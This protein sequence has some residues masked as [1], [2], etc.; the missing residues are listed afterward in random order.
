MVATTLLDQATHLHF[1]GLPIPS[2][3]ISDGTIIVQCPAWYLRDAFWSQPY[4]FMNSFARLHNGIFF[5]CAICSLPTCS[6][7][8]IVLRVGA[9]NLATIWAP[10][11]SSMF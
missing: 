11:C 9:A 4:G 5:E 8:L 3:G 7:V 6:L 1:G 2:G 10:L